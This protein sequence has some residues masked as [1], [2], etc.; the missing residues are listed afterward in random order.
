MKISEILTFFDKQAAIMLGTL[1]EVG[2]PEIRALINIR[3]KDVAPHLTDFFKRNERLLLITNTHSD[4]IGQ[5]RANSSAALYAFDQQFNGLLLT[6]KVLEIADNAVK[7]AL[8]DDSWKMYYPAGKDGGDFSVLEF[9]PS[10]Y[11][12]Y[13]DFN[14]NKG[15]VRE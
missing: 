6:G 4:K 1:N 9:I 5:I 10:E 7:D 2:A 13:V 15:Q 14:V 8:W 12:S 11:K 3:N